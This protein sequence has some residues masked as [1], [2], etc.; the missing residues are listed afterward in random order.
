VRSSLWRVKYRFYIR[1][2]YCCVIVVL[3]FFAIWCPLFVMVFEFGDLCLVF[4]STEFLKV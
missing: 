4:C 2:D 1:R 3:V